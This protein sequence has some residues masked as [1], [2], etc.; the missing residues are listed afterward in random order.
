MILFYDDCTIEIIHNVTKN[1]FH[2]KSV[3]EIHSYLNCN[4]NTKYYSVKNVEYDIFLFYYT[5]IQ[6]KKLIVNKIVIT[7][8]RG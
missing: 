8:E 2:N 4:I 1:A 5:P 3:S 7:H 6:K